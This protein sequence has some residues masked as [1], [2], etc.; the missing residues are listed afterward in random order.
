MAKPKPSQQ[1]IKSATDDPIKEFVSPL[2]YHH[3]GVFESIGTVTF[4]GPYLAVTSKHVIEEHLKSVPPAGLLRTKC[5]AQVLS[6]SEEFN[7]SVV[8]NLIFG[9]F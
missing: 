6:M 7:L 1:Y 9:R 5:Y 3:K 8:D 2:I 4:I